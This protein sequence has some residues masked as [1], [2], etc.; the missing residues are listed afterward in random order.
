MDLTA[1]VHAILREAWKKPKVKQSI[2]HTTATFYGNCMKMCEDFAPNF[3][4]ENW[5]LHHGNTPS[6]TCCSLGNF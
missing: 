6:H 1:S 5:L 4:D 3:E 2:P